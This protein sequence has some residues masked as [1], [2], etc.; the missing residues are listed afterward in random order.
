M[1]F[2]FKVI[3]LLGWEVLFGH[4]RFDEGEAMK[5]GSLLYWLKAIQNSI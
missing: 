1:L 5:M 3:R 4:V 2:V